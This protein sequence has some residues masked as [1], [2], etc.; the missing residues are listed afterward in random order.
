MVQ[1]PAWYDDS[2]GSRRPSL[3]PVDSSPLVDT[4]P[5]QP[6]T[7]H[8]ASP[9]AQPL[10]PMRALALLST[11]QSADIVLPTTDGREIRLRRITE[12]T[13]EQKLVLRQLGICLPEHFAP[14]P[15]CSADSAVA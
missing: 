8:L 12:P 10:T 15:K 14:K 6:P 5:T 9:T 11:V 3:V 2:P 7:A 1:S 4:H 13:A